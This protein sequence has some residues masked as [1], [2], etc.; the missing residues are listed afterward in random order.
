MTDEAL[1]EA[2]KFS[3]EG[4][5]KL[6]EQISNAYS[7]ENYYPSIYAQEKLNGVNG[8]QSSSGLEMSEETDSLIKSTDN[9]ATGG[10]LLG[11]GIRPTQTYWFKDNNFMKNAFET[12]ENGENYYKLLIPDDT[13]TTYWIASRCVNVHSEFCNFHL[14]TIF[15]GRMD[16]KNMFYS[17]GSGNVYSYSQGLFPIVSISYG[18]VVENATGKFS[19][20]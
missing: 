9:G 8:T 15:K 14:G 18:Q 12:A 13:S 20:K 2:H 4:G 19:V 16:A 5:P 10:H 7:S 6:G 11:K 3:N 1:N 17:G